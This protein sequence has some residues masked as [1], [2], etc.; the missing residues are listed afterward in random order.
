MVVNANLN[1]ES[2]RETDLKAIKLIITFVVL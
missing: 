1:R 2:D